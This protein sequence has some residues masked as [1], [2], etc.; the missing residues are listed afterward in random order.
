M[1]LSSEEEASLVASLKA[2][3]EAAF[4]R[5]VRLYQERVFR[6]LLRMVGDRG[7]AEDLTQDVFYSVFKNID[8]F[9]GDS[10][11][12]TWLYR[13][14]TNHS[15]NRLQYFERRRKSRRQEF[16]EQAPHIAE[17]RATMASSAIIARPD[18]QAEAHEMELVVRRAILALDEQ[19]RELVI[20]RD[21]EGLSYEEIK[22]ITG[23]VEGTV[24]SRLH[25]ARATLV[26]LIEAATEDPRRTFP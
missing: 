5:F 12:S 10:K 18:Q 2:R 22:D 6:L 24:K 19:Q 20:L 16:D 4:N 1:D 21:V 14:A 23:L 15:K 8:G 11:L 13:I 3:D 9:R 25:R 26:R 17:E 7:E